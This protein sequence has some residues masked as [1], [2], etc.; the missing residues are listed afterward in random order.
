M[1]HIIGALLVGAFAGGM[2]GSRVRRRPIA[3]S[4]IKGGIA[5]K[6]KIQAAGC[7]AIAETQK[8]VD[9]ARAELDRQGTELHS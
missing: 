5:A 7:T 2:A 3:R 1:H 8:L 6:R 9:E 4:L